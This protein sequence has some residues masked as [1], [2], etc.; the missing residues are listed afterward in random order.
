VL[1]NSPGTPDF[2]RV[3]VPL[4]GVVS[5]ATALGFVAIITFAVRAQKTPVQTGQESLVGKKG[6]VRAELSPH[7]TVLINGELWTAELVEGIGPVA[8][9]VEVEIVQVRGIRLLVKP[10]SRQTSD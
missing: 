6:H 3:S 2:Q 4:V 1:F 7:G 8:S 10:L 9:G 5:L